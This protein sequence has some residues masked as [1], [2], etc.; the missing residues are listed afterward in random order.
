MFSY[1]ITTQ[2]YHVLYATDKKSSWMC[3][4]QYRNSICLSIT[5]ICLRKLGMSGS[6][7]FWSKQ[8]VF[9]CYDVMMM[10]SVIERI[11]I[12]FGGN[13]K[14]KIT[15]IFY[16]LYLQEFFVF[17]LIVMAVGYL[18]THL[19]MWLNKNQKGR[20]DS[21]SDLFDPTTTK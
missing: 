8:Q 19:S 17:V 9:A 16:I 4:L 1:Q 12:G 6:S 18:K 15:H 10:L 2:C 3:A 11:N 20:L 7:A 13:G 14:T 5:E 21:L